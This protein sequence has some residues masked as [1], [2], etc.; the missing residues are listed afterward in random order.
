MG[1]C[2]VAP[3]M[4]VAAK[5]TRS[6]GSGKAFKLNE[7]DTKLE[8]FVGALQFDLVLM[9][10]DLAQLKGI[11]DDATGKLAG[12][13]TGLG[14]HAQGQE[15]VVGALVESTANSGNV[16]DES[17]GDIGEL[18]VSTASR[19]SPGASTRTWGWRCGRCSSRPW[20]DRSWRVWENA[21]SG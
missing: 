4:T 5:R 19:G 16:G 7:D 17:P 18:A 2:A 13:F 1:L 10:K 8:K 11:L 3:W 14:Q 15:R 6:K 21:S 12:S 20:C 9:K